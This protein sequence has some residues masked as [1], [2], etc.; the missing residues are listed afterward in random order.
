MD[1]RDFL[2][3]SASTGVGAAVAGTSSVF[4]TTATGVAKGGGR[5]L[6]A[7]PVAARVSIGSFPFALARFADD[8]ALVSSP[9][10]VEGSA[11]RVLSPLRD[12]CFTGFG[13]G[14]G[15]FAKDQMLIAAVHRTGDGATVRHDLWSHAPERMGGTSQP[16][17]FTAHDDAFS[18]FEITHIP[19]VGQRSSGFFGFAASGAGSILKPG[20]Y[21]LAGPSAATGV[22]PNLA[23]YGYSGDARAPVRESRLLGLDFAYLSF[24]VHGEW[25]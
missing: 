24:V 19:A 1:R 14:A 13:A 6:V 10:Q 7:E 21:V 15:A 25:L 12:V 11:V 8:D 5:A 2:W 9:K 22:A 18:G 3:V 23:R 20:I 16:V 4:N 17:L